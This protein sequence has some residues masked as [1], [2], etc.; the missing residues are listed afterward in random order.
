MAII[1]AVACRDA[2]AAKA[3]MRA[4]LRNLQDAVRQAIAAEMHPGT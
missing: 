4:H 3:A 1:E 2:Q